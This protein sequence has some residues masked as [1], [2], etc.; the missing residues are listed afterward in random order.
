MDNDKAPMSRENF[1]R[2]MHNLKD[3]WDFR[4]KC[5]E[6]GIDGIMEKIQSFDIAV[7]ILCDM[8]HDTEEI[9]PT[10]IYEKGFGEDSNITIE[11]LYNILLHNYLVFILNNI[12][13]NN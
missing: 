6:L 13:N 10:W 2:Y 3:E 8:F 9:L 7:A 11:F 1:V 4:N 12:N 5:Y